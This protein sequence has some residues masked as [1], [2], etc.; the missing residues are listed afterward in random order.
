MVIVHSMGE[1]EE[2]CSAHD[3]FKSTLGDADKEFGSISAIEQV[4]IL[5]QRSIRIGEFRRLSDLSNPTVLIENFSETHTLICPLMRSEGNG[6]K[7]KEL[8]RGETDN[9]RANLRG[10]KVGLEEK[11]PQ[12]ILIL[13]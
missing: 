5:L 11:T 4:L 7:C 3:A 1:I 6:L 12:D 13:F 2:L 8:Y 9:C 10:S